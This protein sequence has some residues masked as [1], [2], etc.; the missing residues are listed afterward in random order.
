M[1]RL[2]VQTT[3]WVLVTAFC[4]ASLTGCGA[5]NNIASSLDNES[6]GGALSGAVH[7]GPNPMIGAAV[8][9]Y[10][11]STVMSPSSS[12]SFGYGQAGTIL[13]TGTTNSS[14]QFSIT[15]NSN[16]CTGQQVYIVAA[17]GNTTAPGTTNSNTA[18]LLMAAI[19]PCSSVVSTA[20]STETDVVIN[21]ASTI[22]AA[23]AL[24]QFMTVSGTTVNISAPANNNAASGSCTN[25]STTHA[26]ISCTAAGLYHAF[27]NAKGLVNAVGTVASPP[28][29]QVNATLPTNTSAIVPQLLINSLANSVEACINSSGS[30]S[31]SC[32]GLMSATWN[33]SLN[34]SL[35]S[36]DAGASSSLTE[37]T[38][39]LQALQALAMYPWQMASATGSAATP[40]ANTTALYNLG[41]SISV[42]SPALTAAPMDFTLAIY[43]SGSNGTAFVGGNNDTTGPWFVATDYND[44]VYATANTSGTN[45]QVFAYTSNGSQ[46]WAP[47]SVPPYGSCQSGNSRCSIATDTLNNLWLINYNASDGLTQMT[48]ST[49]AVGSSYALDTGSHGFSVYV[50]PANNV[51]TVDSTAP[52]TGSTVEELPEG[53]ST[54]ADLDVGGAAVPFTIRDLAFDAYGNMWDASVAGTN[55]GVNL[56]ISSNNSLT[57]PSFT[58]STNTNPVYIEDPDGDTEVNSPMMDI[59]GN[60]WVVDQD[61]I[62][63]VASSGAENVSAFNNNPPTGNYASSLNSVYGTGTGPVS[64]MEVTFGGVN[65][66]AF[67]DGDGKIY[68]ANASTGTGYLTAF[69]PTAPCDTVCTNDG[70]SAGYNA[71]LNPCYVATGTTCEV[72]ANNSG[73]SGAVDVPRGA[74]VDASGALWVA[75]EES[76][77][78]LQVLGIAAPTWPQ[79]NY[80]PVAFAA[81]AGGS[82][83]P[84]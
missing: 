13:G 15:R 8:T 46:L 38:N 66:Y 32:T 19:G 79:A 26:V 4:V 74:A 2:C 75:V 41:S 70:D 67:M 9:L 37:P 21:E 40:D 6:A 68:G 59:K 55:F 69:F 81:N 29:G 31:A 71:F 82:G 25:S 7:G 60:M 73:Q 10:A 18:A 16:S 45:G 56:F 53:S 43:Y 5:N 78:V 83:R 35:P 80:I 76:P 49:G 84:Y 33:S 54:L 17:G 65:R 44:D 27:L 14:G 77:A 28:T 22:A 34:P 51:Y 57:S 23:Y 62:F 52:T 20:G 47:A 1:I 48:E 58:Y 61:Q 11:T 50:D 36:G 63:E 30:S 3:F 12:N 64:P 72:N 24:S 39:T 42:Y